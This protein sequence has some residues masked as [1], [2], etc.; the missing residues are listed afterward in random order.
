MLGLGPKI[1]L[2]SCI[3]LQPQ[4]GRCI[5]A[6]QERSMNSFEQKYDIKENKAVKDFHKSRRMFC[7]I[8]KTVYVA[9]PNVSYS[10]AVW[11]EKKGWMSVEDDTF[12]N[13]APRGFVDAHGDV[14]FCVGYDFRIDAVTESIFFTCL[15]ELVQ[16]LDLAPTAKV[17]GG[18]VRQSTG[19]QWPGRNAYGTIEEVLNKSPL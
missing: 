4:C 2:A 9:E 13:T 16:L 8:E 15:S 17:Y 6:Q 1:L 5:Q 11:F 18:L 14:Y 19:G 3:L 7:I 12:M 10:H